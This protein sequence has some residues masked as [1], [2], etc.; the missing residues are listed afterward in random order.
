MNI[1]SEMK[2]YAMSVYCN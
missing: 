2:P 1:N